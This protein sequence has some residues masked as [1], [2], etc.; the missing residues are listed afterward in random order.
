MIGAVIKHLTDIKI[1]RDCPVGSCSALLCAHGFRA[2]AQP[3][4]LHARCTRL[5][6]FTG[7]FDDIPPD[8]KTAYELKFW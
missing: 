8:G 2:F 3:R 5:G 1:S 7:E 4:S 6:A